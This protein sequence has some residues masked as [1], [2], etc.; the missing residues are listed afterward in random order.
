MPVRSGYGPSVSDGVTTHVELVPPL[1][2]LL[3]F[4]VA[5]GDVGDDVHAIAPAAPAVSAVSRSRRPSFFPVLIAIVLSH[6]SRLGLRRPYAI[7]MP[8]TRPKTLSKS[9]RT[10]RSRPRRMAKLTP[11]RS[12]A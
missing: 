11:R 12:S 5:L 9:R 1:V 6:L 7:A 2:L 3:V 8:R 10:R 4:V